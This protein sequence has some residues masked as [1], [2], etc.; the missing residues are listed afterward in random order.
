MPLP[1]LN[2]V[3]IRARE[4]LIG[5]AACALA[6][7]LLLLAA[8]GSQRVR[9]IDATALQALFDVN[10]P[11]FLSLAQKVAHLGDAV[12]VALAGLVL[13]GIAL[14]RSRPRVA[15]TVLALI[16]VTSVSS[17][18]LKTL[19]AY[20]RYADLHYGGFPVAR[21][22]APEAFPSGH[23][24]AAMTLALCGLLVAPARLRP[25]A[26]FVGAGFALGV[27]F[28]VVVLGSHFPSDVAAGFL[29][30]TGWALVATAGLEAAARRWPPRRH[31]TQAA[32]AVRRA[33]DTATAVG[34]GAAA[35]AG[36]LVVLLAV[37][38]VLASEPTA[39]VD[40]ARAHTTAVFVAGAITAAGTAM[41]VGVA[42]A[43]RRR[44]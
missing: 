33:V 10:R 31:S 18:V 30:A 15:V 36:A 40:Y 12:F 39:A 35:L 21:N 28:S 23:S 8:Y 43:L 41:V 34:L 13:A 2:R 32:A 26:A 11:G 16:A 37:A 19:L 17:Q 22:P 4:L 20:P 29:L 9:R 25:L 42:L 1:T 6:F 44:I 5:A 14:A 7:V 27:G 24:T 38:A 3:V